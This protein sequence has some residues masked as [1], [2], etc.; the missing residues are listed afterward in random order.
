MIYKSGRVGA[1]PSCTS[2]MDRSIS[3]TFTGSSR[4]FDCAEDLNGE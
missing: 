2:G 4:L 1:P 3:T